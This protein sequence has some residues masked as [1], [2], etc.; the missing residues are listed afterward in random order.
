[1]D[2]L[3]GGGDVTT[4]RFDRRAPVQGALSFFRLDTSRRTQ[5][6]SRWTSSRRAKSQRERAIHA[7]RRVV[8]SRRALSSARDWSCPSPRRRCTTPGRQRGDAQRRRARVVRAEVD[9]HRHAPPER[10]LHGCEQGPLDVAACAPRQVLTS[11]RVTARSPPAA[12]KRTRRRRTARL[13]RRAADPP[14]LSPTKP[15]RGRE[16]LRA[17]VST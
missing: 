12:P 17:F 15:P 8:G 5:K 3:G 13:A 9:A 7:S 11:T 10:A 14:M 16:R 4:E 2:A 6:P 1:M